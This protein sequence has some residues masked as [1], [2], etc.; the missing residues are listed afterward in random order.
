MCAPSFLVCA[1]H[2]TCVRAHMPHS[3]EGTLTCSILHLLL[4]LFERLFQLLLFRLSMLDI[5]TQM[6]ILLLELVELFLSQFTLLG[7]FFVFSLK[8]IMK[9]V[10]LLIKTYTLTDHTK[11][12]SE[13]E[14]TQNM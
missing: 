1:H 10:L 4:F 13:T 7:Q 5:F 12:S 8:K 6:N 9:P 14:N 11:N 2:T 3:L